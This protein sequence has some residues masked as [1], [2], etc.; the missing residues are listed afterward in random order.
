MAV[1]KRRLSRARTRARRAQWK[2]SP[3]ALVP[4]T[5]EGRTVHVPRRLA[6]AVERGLLRLD[7]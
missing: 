5:F 7:G 4:V 2:A 6:R 3:T 1:P